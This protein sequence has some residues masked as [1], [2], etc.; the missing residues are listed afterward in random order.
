MSD[1][2]TSAG[3]SG[4]LNGQDEVLLLD[5]ECPDVPNLEE[6][7]CVVAEGVCK[8]HRTLGAHRNARVSLTYNLSVTDQTDKMFIACFKCHSHCNV[9]PLWVPCDHFRIPDAV[10]S[11][12]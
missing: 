9:L 2:L 7:C 10:L 3:V 11:I 1:R 8:L 6:T 4:H 5:E 12:L